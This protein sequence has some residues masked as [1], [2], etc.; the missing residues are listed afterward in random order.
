MQYRQRNQ[1]RPTQFL[2]VTIN[3]TQLTSRACRSTSVAL[4]RP[5]S[6]SGVPCVLDEKKFSRASRWRA[7]PR[8]QVRRLSARSILACLLPSIQF[9]ARRR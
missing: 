4:S 2:F 6:L 5:Y 8:R 9:P 7:L 3:K 1:T